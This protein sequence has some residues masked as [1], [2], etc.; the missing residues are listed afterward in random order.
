[1]VGAKISHVG[2][3]SDV[4]GFIRIP[5]H[6]CGAVGVKPGSTRL[7][8]KVWV[9]F[10]PCRPL[11]EAAEGPIGQTVEAYADILSNLMDCEMFSVDPYVPPI[12]WRED[13]FLNGKKNMTIGY[14]INDGWFEP[15]PAV[16]N[17]VLETVDCLRE[18]DHNL[19]EF[20]PPDISTAVSLRFGAVAIDGGNYLI[21]VVSQLFE[22]INNHI[23]LTQF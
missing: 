18:Q 21:D 8:Q 15:C 4:G 19:V 13:I 10:L 22:F 14:Y 20:R 9:T 12:P 5:A 3:G 2:I 11:M 23:N 17:A 7:S 6:F 1:M 16:K